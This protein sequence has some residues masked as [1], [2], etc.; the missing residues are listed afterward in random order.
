MTTLRN[1][2]SAF[3]GG[4]AAQKSKEVEVRLSY[5]RF[6]AGLLRMSYAVA[7]FWNASVASGLLGN[8][9]GG[10]VR[11]WRCDR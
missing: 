9:L 7:T 10:G 8:L 11:G 5:M 4:C 2:S 3:G 6:E 1:V